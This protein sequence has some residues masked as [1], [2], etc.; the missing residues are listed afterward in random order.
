MLAWLNSDISRWCVRKILKIVPAS[1]RSYINTKMNPTDM[2]THGVSVNSL[3]ASALWPQGPD[4]L[5][6]NVDFKLGLEC[7]V[8]L[9]V[10]LPEQRKVSLRM[11][12]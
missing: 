4:F 12:L 7:Q 9:P 1:N 11:S 10:H 6:N 2:A 3:I 8:Y 5:R